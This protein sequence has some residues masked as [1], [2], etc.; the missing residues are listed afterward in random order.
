FS[1]TAAL[2]GIY[3]MTLVVVD[4]DGGVSPMAQST[5]TVYGSAL[6]ADP[7]N[8]AQSALVIGGSSL[9]DAVNVSP[10]T[11]STTGQ[12]SIRRRTGILYSV[13]LNSVPGRFIIYGQD[14]NDS[15]QMDSRLS[16]SMII[17]GNGGNDTVSAG[18]GSAVILG[19]DGDD[20]I[21]AGGGRDILV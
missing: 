5:M 18:N 21:A 12:V 2:P 8:P 19:G 11:G 17:Y 16:G 14:G 7:L 4:D 3:V 1:F 15:I 9:A 13:N 6:A 10:G 20:S